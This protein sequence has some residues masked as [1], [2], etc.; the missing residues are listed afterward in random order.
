VSWLAPTGNSGVADYAR[1]LH[2]ATPD[3]AGVTVFHLGNNPLHGDLY[4]RLLSRRD[5][6]RVVI[7][8]D[9]VLHHFLLGSLSPNEYVAEFIYNYGEWNRNLAQKLWARRSHSGSAPEYFAYPM[10]KRAMEA[11][12]LVIAHNPAASR[13][14]REHGARRVELLP[15]FI[16]QPP[17]PSAQAVAEWR[18]KQGLSRDTCLFGV[19]GHLRESKRIPAVRRALAKQTGPVALLL[20]GEWGSAALRESVDLPT[21]DQKACPTMRVGQVPEA[22]F[23][24]LMAA[25]DVGVNLRYPSAGESSGVLARLMALGKPAMV[26]RGEELAHLPAGIV[27]PVSPGPGE[28]EELALGM[29]YLAQHRVARQAIGLAAREFALAEC[30]VEVIAQRLARLLASVDS[31]G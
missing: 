3:V 11:A 12:D 9:A 14:A 20:Q 22:E 25:T 10:L 16:T 2:N 5:A 15:H 27:W 8:H 7:L 18:A 21:T 28:G 29:A 17:E 23:Q 19:F 4:R 6:K 1:V 31:L 13:L 26:T 24:L 30:A